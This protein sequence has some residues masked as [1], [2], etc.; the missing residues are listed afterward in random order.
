MRSTHPL[1]ASIKVSEYLELHQQ[2]IIKEWE[3][4]IIFSNDDSF[5]K[6]LPFNGPAMLA[7]ITKAIRDGVSDQE[8]DA[9]AKK[10]A[11]EKFH[12]NFNIDD[13]VYNI[14]KG[15][16]IIIKAIAS[17][18]LCL[19][20]L[21][22]IMNNINEFFDRFS[23]LAVKHYT[24]IKDQELKDKLLYIKQ[25]QKDR[26][27]IL[28]QM[29][30]AFVHEFRNPLT[31]VLGFVK[32]MKSGEFKPTYLDIIEH[33]LN[34]LNFRITQFLHTSKVQTL[35]KDKETINLNAL[36]DE[37]LDF[38]YPNLL[39]GEIDITNSFNYTH[40]IQCY[41]DEIKQVL[42]NILLNSIDA[43]KLN[44][45]PRKIKISSTLEGSNIKISISNNGPA[46]LEHTLNTI[47]E[48]F[49]TTK[50]TGTGIGLFVCKQ[51]IE[52][53]NGKISCQST[54]EVTTFDILLPLA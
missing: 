46:I 27:S 41:R 33:E 23:H 28:G 24:L 38:I 20:S 36:M 52:K 49:Y 2:E 54:P 15:R 48:P 34:Q 8:F 11:N 4:S 16:S 22:P 40:P 39:E 31:A 35:D 9:R 51:I 37:T 6:Q 12:A 17:S 3:N 7:L 5:K 50:D 10:V 14:N 21:L 25:I 43:V 29:S 42:I 32:L 26:F 19:Q 18:G 53:H 44:E 45:P 30:S 1:P 47:F 13:F